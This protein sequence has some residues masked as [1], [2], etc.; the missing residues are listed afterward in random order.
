MGQHEPMEYM[1]MG[2]ND[3][4]ISSSPWI[5]SRCT[6]NNVEGSSYCVVCEFS[7]DQNEY[8]AN[9]IILNDYLHPIFLKQIETKQDEENDDYD[10]QI[11]CAIASSLQNICTDSEDTD[12]SDDIASISTSNTVKC[13]ITNHSNTSIINNKKRKTKTRRIS[14]ADYWQE[15]NEYN[16]MFQRNL[17]YIHKQN[18]LRMKENGNETKTLWPGH[19]TINVEAFN[20]IKQHRELMDAVPSINKI[21]DWLGTRWNVREFTIRNIIRCGVLTK[22]LRRD[23]GNIKRNKLEIV[24]HGTRSCNDQSIINKGLVTGGTKGVPIR[25][26]AAYGKGVYCTPSLLTASGYQRG[27]LFVCLV[28]H[29]KCRKSGN[30]YVVPNDDDILPLYLASFVYSGSVANNTIFQFKPFWKPLNLNVKANK[31][32]KVRRK[33]SAFHKLAKN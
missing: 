7:F 15:M 1:D 23:H 26:G 33:W 20:T 21:S 8:T 3:D 4:N 24:Y 22:F 13:T 18:R 5:C 6:F 16:L 32:R 31:E 29:K 2:Y 28:R 11:Q 10:E 17:K 12:F 9:P 14:F 30:I 25:H 27:S 19:G